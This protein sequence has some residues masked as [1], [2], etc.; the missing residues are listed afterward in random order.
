MIDTDYEAANPPSQI[1][2]I[3]GVDP[4]DRGKIKERTLEY[5]S[6]LEGWCSKE[7]AG[8]LFD[9][10]SKTRPKTVV[11]IGVWGGKSLIPM[12]LALKTNKHGKIYGIDP[13]SPFASIEEIKEEINKNYWLSVN[14]EWILLGLID[15]I[16]QIHL[17]GQI[18]LIRSTS[19]D[20]PLITDIDIL[21]VDGNHSNKTSMEDVNKW[22]PYVKNGGWIIFDDMTWHENGINTTADAVHWLDANCVRLAV[23]EDISIWGCVWGIWVKP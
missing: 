6:Q 16:H 15:V 17:G 7:K 20:A 23:F 18:E 8:I 11:E 9:L 4:A 13:W 10:V 19:I 12:A 14:H 3:L 21:H 2:Y 1:E 22:V 5:T